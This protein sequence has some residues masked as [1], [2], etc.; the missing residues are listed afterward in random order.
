M[1]P[2][3]HHPPKPRTY[4][5]TTTTTP[6]SSDL[7]G[8]QDTSLHHARRQ[9][10]PLRRQV[11]FSKEEEEE[12]ERLKMERQQ[13]EKDE[14]ETK[15]SLTDDFLKG[16]CT[17]KCSRF[18]YLTRCVQQD[19]HPLEMENGRPKFENCVKKYQRSYAGASQHP[20]DLRPLDTLLSTQTYLLDLL[21][22]HPLNRV[23]A[24][25]WDRFRAIRRDISTQQIMDPQVTTIYEQIIRFHLL[26]LFLRPP[27]LDRFQELTQL[28]ADIYIYVY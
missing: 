22:L 17:T 10:G 15:K 3:F 12:Y 23:Y 2:T 11:F 8:S 13:F 20:N 27:E 5:S 18:E 9:R 14:M 21:R 26:C 19:I 25:I 6:P 1:F 16:V 24:F 28:N 4:P 7:L